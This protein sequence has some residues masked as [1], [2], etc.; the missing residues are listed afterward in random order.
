MNLPLKL[1]LELRL[2]VDFVVREKKGVPTCNSA[3]VQVALGL[4]GR[5]VSWGDVGP[6]IDWPQPVIHHWPADI[7][8]W[9]GFVF[10]K[11]RYFHLR[12]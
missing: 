7:I 11:M 12:W 3:C 9:V 2:C 8:S 4:V 1:I 10:G 5:A 6:S